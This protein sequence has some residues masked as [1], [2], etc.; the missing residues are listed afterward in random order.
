MS[1]MIVKDMGKYHLMA[2][3]QFGIPHTY[4]M[5]SVTRKFDAAADPS[6]N[7]AAAAHQQVRARGAVKYA[8]IKV[9]DRVKIRERGDRWGNRRGIFS[10]PNPCSFISI[11]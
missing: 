7:K 6:T 5:A 9:T 3:V 2:S 8:D 10:S 1:T 11:T 4:L